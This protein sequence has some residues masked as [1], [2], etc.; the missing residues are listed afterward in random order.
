MAP[1]S[2]TQAQDKTTAA[3]SASA[4]APA[5]DVAG[6]GPALQRLGDPRRAPSP[7]DVLLL[8]G[9]LGQRGVQ[10]LLAER[11]AGQAQRPAVRPGGINRMSQLPGP[12]RP[13][14]AAAISLGATT[15]LKANRAVLAEPLARAAALPP[16]RKPNRLAGPAALAAQFDPAAQAP[17]IEAEGTSPV[18]TGAAKALRRSGRD[19]ELARIDRLVSRYAITDPAAARALPIPTQI[20]VMRELRGTIQRG[21]VA[22]A[23]GLGVLNSFVNAIGGPL[24]HFKYLKESH[25]AE[26]KKDWK[27]LETSY[28]S[29]HL[30]RMAK[31]AKIIKEIG[32][33]AGWVSL[34]SSIGALIAA[35]FAPAGLAAS[36][37][38]GSIS[39]IA[40]LV[41]GAVGLISGGLS[42]VLAISTLRKALAIKNAKSVERRRLM[43]LFYRDLTGAISGLIA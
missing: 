23:I 35:A 10:R 36:A 27:R 34:M 8:Q 29:V 41:A 37:V 12:A 1:K 6:F 28:D 15:G 4:A 22:K 20:A 39:A 40:G 43:L 38:L 42:T 13:G 14:Q 24:L 30:E 9:A 7:A 2:H 17:R 32:A 25:R 5:Q 16:G 21:G 31:A 11:T 26:W 33:F 19:P 3:K 18:A